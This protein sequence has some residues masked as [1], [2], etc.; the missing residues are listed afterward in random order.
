MAP[1]HP[2]KKAKGWTPVV[3][4][5]LLGWNLAVTGMYLHASSVRAD[6][7]S[8]AGLHAQVTA[9]KRQVAARDGAIKTLTD[10]LRRIARGNVE[11]IEK[12]LAGT[13]ITVDR[14]IRRGRSGNQGGPFIPADDPLGGAARDVER[15]ESLRR[16][17]RVL[18]LGSPIHADHEVSSGFGTR[19]DPV[20]GRRAVHEGIDLRAPLRTP[21]HATGPGTVV[22]TGTKG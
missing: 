6:A 14:L 7:P 3:V 18:P 9:L 16:V 21:V 8:C 2:Q 15:W 19:K 22:F 5:G 20:N 11:S 12:A 13:G 10:R 4:A 17:M 1:D